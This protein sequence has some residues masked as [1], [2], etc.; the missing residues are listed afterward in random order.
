MKNFICTLIVLLPFLSCVL[1]RFIKKNINKNIAGILSS[2]CISIT[3]FGAIYLFIDIYYL[4]GTQFLFVL[5]NWI[6]LPQLSINF[7]IS[8]TPLTSIMLMM[9]TIISSLVHIFSIEYMRKDDHFIDFMSYLSFFTLA[10]IVL[11]ISGNL[12]QLFLGWEGVGI[13]SYL[14]IGFWHS[15]DSANI[16]AMKS[17]IVN[18]VGDIGLIVGIVAIYYL[19]NSLEIECILNHA[20]SMKNSSFNVYGYNINSIEIICGLLFF[21]AMAKSAQF[22]LHTWLP[23]AMEGPTPVSALIHAA[24]M[25]T[26]GVFL[27]ARLSSLFELAVFTKIIMSFIGCFTAFFAGTIALVQTDIKKVIAYST[28]SQ[29]GYMFLAL[30]LSAYNIAIFHLFTHA[31]FKALL[32]LSAGSIIYN[33]SHRQDIVQMGG[34]YKV[35]PITFCSML[36]GTLS[37]VGIPLF[38]GYYSKDPILGIAWINNDLIYV[39]ALFTV[40]LTALYSWRMLI[41]IFSGQSKIDKSYLS[42]INEKKYLM[43]IPMVILIIGSILS[44]YFGQ[45]VFFEPK[46]WMHCVSNDYIISNMPSVVHYMPL[47]GS[48]FGLIIA[49]NIYIISPK[50][51]MWFGNNFQRVQD[52]L[53]NNWY[54]DTCYNKIFISSFIKIGT[55]FT[56][57]IE[58]NIIDH[59]V[60]NLVVDTFSNLSIKTSKMHRKLLTDYILIFVLGFVGFLIFGFWLF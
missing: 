43:L 21:G 35:M 33:L 59:F 51:R 18:R 52:F 58:I 19:F 26:A 1:L 55:V 46:F 30:G 15:K 37:I 10:M 13:A 5:F 48:L 17:F 36:I 47:I 57:V 29:L 38:S 42:N 22:G 9:V 34:L 53:Y 14:L 16:A 4:S 11:I 12:L 23:D 32:F 41:L 49:C 8:I 56:K 7:S 50:M 25:V 60:S 31:F 40:F 39:I 45:F 3:A 20:N 27:I 6:E 2:S 54:I 28:C 44:G 24:T